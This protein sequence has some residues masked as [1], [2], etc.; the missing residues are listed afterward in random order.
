MY[1]RKMVAPVQ[2]CARLL[3]VLVVALVVFVVYRTC[4]SES[5]APDEAA[6]AAPQPQPPLLSAELTADE[7]AVGERT[8]VFLWRLNSPLRGSC[9]LTGSDDPLPEQ[10]PDVELPVQLHFHGGNL[11][12]EMAP[13][14]PHADAVAAC[15][16]DQVRVFRRRQ[17]NGRY[18]TLRHIRIACEVPQPDASPLRFLH[19]FEVDAAAGTVDL[20][21]CEVPREWES[22]IPCHY[23]SLAPSGLPEKC[24]GSPIQRDMSRLVHALASIDSAVSAQMAAGELMSFAGVLASAAPAPGTPWPN[25]WGYYAPDA[26]R[27]ARDI[28]AT[29]VFLQE[30]NCFDSAELAAFVNS[31]IFTAIFGHRFSGSDGDVADAVADI[32]Y[33]PVDDIQAEQESRPTTEETPADE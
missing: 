14:S 12:V 7:A 11:R 25:N 2:W 23:N 31:L 5:S 26:R 8:V 1:S 28:T 13:A 17:P 18:H 6:P 21:P 19:E 4:R 33:V 22:M 15:R 16:A 27:A 9:V 10:L 24:S 3:A 30:N 32:E 29:L 20:V